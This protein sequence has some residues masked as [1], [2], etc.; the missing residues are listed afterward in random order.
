MNRKIESTE[1][2]EGAF[3]SLALKSDAPVSMMKAARQA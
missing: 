2:R 3:H 1:L